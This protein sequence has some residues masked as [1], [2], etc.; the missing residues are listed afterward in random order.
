MQCPGDKFLSRSGLAGQQ[1]GGRRAGNASRKVVNLFHYGTC[2][3][4]SLETG[5]CLGVI[6]AVGLRRQMSRFFA[7]QTATIDRTLAIFIGVTPVLQP[8]LIVY[9]DREIMIMDNPERVTESMHVIC[10]LFSS[11]CAANKQLA[12]K[13]AGVRK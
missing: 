3:D 6:H 12:P 4:H 8:K 10:A 7:T 5:R 2:A 9:S 1:Y 11:S 13:L